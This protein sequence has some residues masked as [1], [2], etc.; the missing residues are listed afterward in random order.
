[1]MVGRL[2]ASCQESRQ[3][4]CQQEIN[5]AFSIDHNYTRIV[6]VVDRS[7]YTESRQMLMLNNEE[8]ISKML[9]SNVLDHV[10][11][12]IN[13][14]LDLGVTLGNISK[15]KIVGN[16]TCMKLNCLHT[17]FKLQ[18]DTVITHR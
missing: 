18:T 2:T 9:E 15:R 12:L 13:K 14:D 3:R 16:A 4:K 8:N 7:I 6:T 10:A 17:M 5:K 1:M 11:S